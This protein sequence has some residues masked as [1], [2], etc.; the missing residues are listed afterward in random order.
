[1]EKIHS[2]HQLLKA[3]T[4]F[5]KDVDYIIKES[6]IVIVDEHTGRLMPGRRFSEGMHSAIEAKENVDI[7]EETK[8][9]A[10]I[11]LQNLFRMF[12]K[13]SGM[14]G[15]AETEAQE[16][17]HIYDLDVIVIPTNRPVIR[18]DRNDVVFV[19]KSDKIKYI[20]D[21]IVNIHNA[22]IPLLI[23]TAS[24]ASSEYLDR[25]LKP[26]KDASG[27][28]LNYNILNA[29]NNEGEAEIVAE[30]GDQGSV[31]VATNMAGRGTDIKL[32][33][34]IK[35]L[36]ERSAMIQALR[37]R[38]AD[39]KPV[40]ICRNDTSLQ[41]IDYL[42]EHDNYLSDKKVYF[43]N[44]EGDDKILIA[45][46][47]YEGSRERIML[48]DTED[49]KERNVCVE[50]DSEGNCLEYVP[51]GLYVLGTEKHESRRI[52]RQ[53]RGRSGRQGDPG[54]SQFT[55]S[56]EDDLMRVFGADRMSSLIDR[57]EA[58]SGDQ[59]AVS[60]RLLTSSIENAQKRIENINFERRKFLLEYDDV[61]NKQR[62]VVYELRDFFL[63]RAL[64]IEYVN[65]DLFY[66]LTDKLSADLKKY[67]NDDNNV[68]MRK[69]RNYINHTFQVNISEKEFYDT[70]KNN[71]LQQELEKRIKQRM[72]REN[73]EI[74]DYVYENIP[75]MAE[76]YILS[77]IRPG[78]FKEEWPY[79]IINDYLLAHFSIKTEEPDED[80]SISEFAE[81][82]R[83]KIERRIKERCEIPRDFA[84][85]LNFVMTQTFIRAIDAQWV[86]QLY[87]LEAIREGITLRGY[88]KK[89]PLVEFKKE[90]Y[91]LFS[92]LIDS[93]YA[94]FIKKFF[95]S[96]ILSDIED[97]GN[98]QF[99]E[100]RPVIF[101]GSGEEDSRKQ[102]PFERK[103]KKIGRNDPCWCG[104]GKK[105]KHCHG[106]NK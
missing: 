46:S 70:V 55:V 74:L 30:A 35:M 92:D 63:F 47:G 23:G 50:F 22:G 103:N 75:P 105:Y 65:K 81:S 19:R 3:Y 20:A 69:M 102:E 96:K 76:E 87:E 29:K 11:T 4:L 94:E 106:R 33:K 83:E 99:E 57:M 21:R 78:S 24:V 73:R 26:R 5:T 37:M 68:E 56:L 62:E 49:L 8:T 59:T 27:R 104:S 98:K 85:K 100:K 71:A 101:T 88:A 84:D 1:S 86:E 42:R 97:I 79:D 10:T 7:E 45:S 18:Q 90:A 51:A 58:M 12:V 48:P 82:V 32:G 25:K 16:F 36:P 31:T 14:T 34:T 13:L 41:Y 6:K 44:E 54:T 66:K 95:E 91:L 28:S 52:D 39:R 77:V 64:P 80:I 67:Y 9:L 53:L 72:D 43:S 15:T 2:V 40:I 17:K 61:I 89:D 60:H 93:I 38:E